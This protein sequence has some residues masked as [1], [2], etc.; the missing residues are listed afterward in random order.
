[1][2]MDTHGMH[3]WT[4]HVHVDIHSP[5]MDTHAHIQHV[6]VDTW[7]MH[8]GTHTLRT[9][10]ITHEQPVHMHTH[11]HIG[12]AAFSR[13]PH[14][15]PSTACMSSTS[16]DSPRELFP[17]SQATPELLRVLVSTALGL[18]QEFHWCP[19]PRGLGW[20]PARQSIDR[21]HMLP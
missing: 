16:L 4:H 7:H 20:G 2:H 8:M 9:A 19:G 6:Y 5:H 1:M 13:G 3:I 14:G 18:R 17:W 15:K 10:H 12:S 11:S 21:C